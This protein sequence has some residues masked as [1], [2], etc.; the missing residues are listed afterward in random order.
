MSKNNVILAN[1]RPIPHWCAAILLV[2]LLSGCLNT[3]EVAV[4]RMTPGEK[5]Y[6]E[7]LTRIHKGT[8]KSEVLEILGRPSGSSSGNHFKYIVNA[9]TSYVQDQ[10]TV[11]AGPTL[12]EV[13]PKGF[14][15]RTIPGQSVAVTTPGHDVTTGDSFVEIWFSG[16]KVK[17]SRFVH[18]WWF[19]TAFDYDP[20]K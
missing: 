8:S 14:T 7:K 2:I 17:K 1:K 16:E 9:R 19:G 5:G 11:F 15:G 3:R 13:G 6:A 10:T 4:S 18:P 20:L 12:S